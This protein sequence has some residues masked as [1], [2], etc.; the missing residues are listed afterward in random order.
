MDQLQEIRR[1]L[2]RSR[3]LKAIAKEN[4]AD[5][6]AAKRRWKAARAGKPYIGFSPEHTAWTK[7]AIGTGFDRRVKQIFQFDPIPEQLPVRPPWLR[8]DILGFPIDTRGGRFDEPA[9]AEELEAWRAGAAKRHADAEANF[10]RSRFSSI[11]RT[12]SMAPNGTGP[13]PHSIIAE[14]DALTA[15][16]FTNLARPFA[17]LSLDDRIPWCTQQ[18]GVEYEHHLGA[19]ILIGHDLIELKLASNS[20]FQ[21]EWVVQVLRQLMRDIDDMYEFDSVH[22]YEGRTGTLVRFPLE[23]IVKDGLAAVRALARPII[24]AEPLRDGGVDAWHLEEE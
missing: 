13:I 4:I 23:E 15:L 24:E 19:D 22:F 1:G 21:S 18:D 12:D 8:H 20:T 14:L 3:Q 11:Y 9:T 7:R 10:A 2:G 6:A 17:H 5:Q 16:A